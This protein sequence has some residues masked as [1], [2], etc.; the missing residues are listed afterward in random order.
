M[1]SAGNGRWPRNSSPIHYLPLPCA[2]AFGALDRRG[3]GLDFRGVDL[4]ALFAG[5]VDLGVLWA[6]DSPPLCD[7]LFLDSP[8]EAE[9][10]AGGVKGR[11]PSFE[12]PRFAGVEGPRAS[13]GDMAGA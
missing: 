5:G 4:G 9:F 1:A 12:P 11:K 10:L 8:F 7:S 13:F 3:G 6:R 2:G